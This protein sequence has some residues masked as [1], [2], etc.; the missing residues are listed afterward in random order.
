MNL[1]KRESCGLPSAF[2]APCRAPLSRA[3]ASHE[4]QRNMGH[5]GRIKI[6]TLVW[7]MVSGIEYRAHGIWVVYRHKDFTNHG[8]WHPPWAIAPEGR[9]LM[10]AWSFGAR[11]NRRNSRHPPI[12]PDVRAAYGLHPHV[13]VERK[14]S[15]VPSTSSGNPDMVYNITGPIFH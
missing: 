12:A 11:Q 4:N 8:F 13:A 2:L 14:L 6:R 1:P 15:P 5:K 10:F 7:Y 3:S 9:I